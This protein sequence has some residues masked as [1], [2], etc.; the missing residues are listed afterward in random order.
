MGLENAKSRTEKGEGSRARED[1]QINYEDNHIGFSPC[2]TGRI[3]A[4]CPVC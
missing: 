2:L 4:S 3:E 1:G